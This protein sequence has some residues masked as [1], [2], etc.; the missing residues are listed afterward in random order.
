MSA[1]P[2]QPELGNPGGYRH[3]ALLYRGSEEFLSGIVSFAGPAADAGYP[4]LVLLTP[5]KIA[6][7]RTALGPAAEK[8][9]FADITDAG[10][11]PGQQSA[12]GAGSP[13]G[14]RTRASC[15]ASPRRCSPGGPPPSWPNAGC[16][17]SC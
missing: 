10:G 15:A 17:K 5:A 6:A 11:N 8:V 14:T 4:V 1:E 16:M 13:R 2:D 7:V 9:E 3:E 12:C